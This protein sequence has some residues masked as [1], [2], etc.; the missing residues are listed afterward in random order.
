VERM[1]VQSE[2]V[3]SIGGLAA[4]MAH[5]INNPLAL[6]V[7]YV[8]NI[9]KRLAQDS[10][11]NQRVAEECG[12][13]L[14]HLATYLEKRD[15][16]SM[17]DKIHEAGVRIN[18]ISSNMLDFSRKAESSEVAHHHVAELLDQAVDLAANVYSP[19]R[20]FS[21]KQIKIL[22]E[23]ADDLPQVLCHGNEIQQVFLNLFKNGTE[24]M[25]EKEFG[26][27]APH[28][29]LRTYREADL[30]VVE[31]EDNGPGMTEQVRG[32]IL[33][34]FFTTKPMGEG[35]GLGLSVSYFIITDR[36][37]GTMEVQSAEGLWTRFKIGLSI[38][39]GMG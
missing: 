36:H 23:Y 12:L 37:K 18:K 20:V 9:K 2:K 39:G 34:P 1:M 33:E 30:V 25:A 28:F 13:R 4:G 11:K 27:Q 24:A 26:E 10:R 19:K 29:I 14:D 21:F 31:V 15:I 5:E 8:P 3:M 17:L 7:G 22:R 38:D 6:V 16:P 35:T 32:R